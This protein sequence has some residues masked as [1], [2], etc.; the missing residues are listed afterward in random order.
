MKTLTTSASLFAFSIIGI[1]GTAGQ[2]EAQIL[3]G[4]EQKVEQNVV[5]SSND[6]K[7]KI[8][9][10]ADSCKA[11]K[12]TDLGTCIESKIEASDLGMRVIKSTAASST[13]YRPSLWN[14][15]PLSADAC[16][17]GDFSNG[18][19][20]W[21]GYRLK[22]NPG[23][24]LPLQDY[25]SA[26]VPFTS[27][28]CSQSFGDTCLNVETSGTDP[29]VS[30]INKTPY[31]NSL[32]M[33]GYSSAGLGAEGV[34]KKFVKTANRDTYPFKYA[35]SMQQSHG[36]HDSAFFAAIAMDSSGN[37]V[38]VVSDSAD[39]TNPFVQLQGSQYYRDWHCAKLDLSPIP[40][41]DEVLVFFVNSDCA[42]GG[43]SGH[44][45]ID[46][47]CEDCGPDD[48]EG[49][50]GI[51]ADTDD[52]LEEGESQSIGGNFSVPNGASNVSVDLKLYQN[53]T[54]VST[55]P[56]ASI[57]GNNYTKTVVRTD[58]P[59]LD[60]FDIVAEMT[61][62][63]NGVSVTKTSD[64]AN[65]FKAGQNNDICLNCAP[66]PPCG[67]CDTCCPPWSQGQL[68]EM[69]SFEQFNGGYR[70]DFK[71]NASID[72]QMN[73]WLNYAQIMDPSVEAVNV[74]FVPR[75]CTT[76][77]SVTSTASCTPT[78]AFD[79]DT[80]NSGIDYNAI[81]WDGSVAN[82]KKIGQPYSYSAGWSS[83]SSVLSR[84]FQ[85]NRLYTITA[86]PFVRKTDGSYDFFDLDCPIATMKLNFQIQFGARMSSSAKPLTS[87]STTTRERLRSTTSGREMLDTLKKLEDISK[88]S[89][90]PSPRKTEWTNWLNLDRP[91]GNGDYQ[92]LKGIQ[93]KGKGCPKPVAIECRTVRGKI[94]WRQTGE[95]MTCNVT[96][97]GYCTN[98]S[99]KDGRCEDYEVRLLC[100]TE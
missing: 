27:N 80:V 49:Y 81:E 2:A 46:Q 54:F 1:I 65:G 76:N 69:F 14:N 7:A 43:H 87:F 34:A 59:S 6:L 33:G 4:L 21:S 19:S 36:A 8:Q 5:I 58:F 84:E 88:T 35:F 86:Y 37:V 79:I 66:P 31:G 24:G 100:P 68:E 26:E 20:G 9:T 57:S 67:D 97:G 15:T 62:D 12:S 85:H 16:S 28:A 94:D 10:F 71:T 72:A 61:F 40:P 60:C 75:E 48:N 90:S 56:G 44:T 98:K 91:G 22:R 29:I 55:I 63:Y 82:N 42:Q 45:Y 41:G 25:L 93:D 3:Q 30:A 92:T 47:I 64:G 50:V 32:V 95:A 53:G 52:C 89:P 73:A 23:G 38:D 51:D 96:D 78:N 39:A 17:N 18:Q 74:L 99:Q 11:D 13:N 83:A 77:Q 70:V